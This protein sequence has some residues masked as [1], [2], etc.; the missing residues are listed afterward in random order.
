[1]PLSD[2]GICFLSGNVADCTLLADDDVEDLKNE[3]IDDLRVFE[4]GGFLLEG[5]LLEGFVLEGIFAC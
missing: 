2:R 5:F 3:E 1:M 4:N